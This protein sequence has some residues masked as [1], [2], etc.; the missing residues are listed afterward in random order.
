MFL[1]KET[2]R[3]CGEA[4]GFRRPIDVHLARC[5]PEPELEDE[6]G[7]TPDRSSLSGGSLMGR[8]DH[9]PSGSTGES[10]SGPNRLSR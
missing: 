6:P 2:R 1:D 3:V 7:Y 4:A 5:V 10:P 9:P 8:A